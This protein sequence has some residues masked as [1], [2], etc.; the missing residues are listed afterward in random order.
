MKILWITNIPSPY[1][2]DFFC[3]MGKLCEL[4]VL[5]EM[6]TSTER[7]ISWKNYNFV[8]FQG[9][10][11]DG[12]EVDVDKTICFQIFKYLK[13]KKYDYIIV[14]NIATPTGI[15][16]IEYMKLRKIR[17]I[18]EGDGGFAKSGKGVKECLKK[19]LIQGAELYFSTSISHDDYWKTYGVKKE[20]I[21]RYPFTSI[22][23][24]DI[25][26]D[27][28]ENHKKQIIR[29]E[30]GITAEN[31]ILSVGRFINSKGYDV[32][33]KA[34]KYI[35]NADLYIIGGNPTTEYLKIIED[36]G[37]SNVHFIEF[38]EKEEL[39]KYF[40]MATVFVLP[41][42]G[43][44]WG[45]VVNEAMAY[46]LPVITTDKCVAGIELIK[47]FEN[48][49]ITPVEDEK[50]LTEKVNLIL[51]D[52]ALRLKMANNN[53]DIVRQYTIESMVKRHMEVLKVT[54]ILFL[55]YAINK[56]EA[57]NL[58]GASIAGN[59]MQINVLE[60]LSLYQ[61][62]NIKCIT[63]YPT[64]AYPRGKM[65]VK[66]QSIRLFDEFYSLKV[67]FINLP[68][69]KQFFE[70]ISTY[71]T[72]KKIIKKE[73]IDIIFTFNMFPQ[74]GLP[75][76]WLKKKYGCKIVSLLA[77]L[78][79]DDNVGKKGLYILLRKIFDYSTRKAILCC[80]KIIALNKHAVDLYAPGLEYIIV[81]GGAGFE[82]I[83][84]IPIK[85]FSRKN[86]VYSGALVEYSG[87]INLI[88]AMKYVSDKEVVLDIYGSGQI[89]EYVMQCADLTQNV[90]YHGK[91]DNNTMKKIQGEAYLLINP[92]PI[93]NLISK[94]TFPSK[95][96]EYMISGTPV[97]TTKLNGFTD[98]Y[99]DTMFFVD[100]NDPIILAD[101]INEIMSLSL[102]ELSEK[103]LK[104]WKFVSENKTWRKQCEK[105]YK[106]ISD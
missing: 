24:N 12:K 27:F 68:I 102:G 21:Y 89:M 63:I 103:A 67:G 20:K 41:T 43:D 83:M 88:E 87:I 104:A 45:L 81:E 44:S 18:L 22:K 34:C 39:K 74:I 76:K 57:L 35:N 52:D 13:K 42:R 23:E 5:F 16:A 95:I 50:A 14:T 66:K 36:L 92:R 48:G 46:G 2:V 28:I 86:I 96:F 60:N 82:D 30:L 38:K 79:I 97:L 91:V 37:L 47:N 69:L 73:R 53:I 55:G 4:T 56:E 75:A 32:L 72:A 7:D 94:V 64:A 19:H 15:M 61:D 11:M 1:R 40:L 106:F 90:K 70:T 26:C 29:K 105:I 9:I 49:F 101:K 80:D 54:N 51:E 78:P 71:N 3:E 100:S 59:K 77:D 98:D 65:F 17:Y 62:L 8:N 85:T 93:E 84:D 10:I 31:V 33:L 25:C 58:Y 99:M 6:A